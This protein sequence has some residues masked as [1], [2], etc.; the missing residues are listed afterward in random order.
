VSRHPRDAAR[1]QAHQAKIEDVDRLQNIM[2]ADHVRAAT[3]R[4]CTLG[5]TRY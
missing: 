3:H 1:L 4:D 2:A 5:P